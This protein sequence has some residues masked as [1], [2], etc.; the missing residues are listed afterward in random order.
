MSDIDEAM[1]KDHSHGGQNDGV[2]YGAGDTDGGQ[3]ECEGGLSD[4]ENE[5]KEDGRVEAVVEARQVLES[6]KEFRETVLEY[7]LKGGWNIQLT[8]WEGVKSEAK[9]GVEVDEAV[10]EVLPP[11]D[12]RLCA[13]HI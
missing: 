5:C 10:D 12:Y 13:R 9:C 3:N 1:N 6:V 11:V 7:A 2:V 8:R 4:G